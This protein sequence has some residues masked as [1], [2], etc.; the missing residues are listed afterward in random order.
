[1]LQYL[2]PQRGVRAIGGAHVFRTANRL[3]IRRHNRALR[4]G[5][6]PIVDRNKIW[7]I[8]IVIELDGGIQENTISPFDVEGVV[9][10]DATGS[11]DSSPTNLFR[12]AERSAQRL[13]AI[14]CFS[15][16]RN[17]RE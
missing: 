9:V 8:I 1:M 13:D 4:R 7:C 15:S 17:R 10:Y 3:M 6:R 11:G 5:E 16:A 12:Y 2:R 14:D